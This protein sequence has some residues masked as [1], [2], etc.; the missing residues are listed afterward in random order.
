M[1]LNKEASINFRVTE[2]TKDIAINV[3]SRNEIKKQTDLH[4]MAYMLGME[5]IMEIE[6]KAA[7]ADLMTLLAYEVSKRAKK[8]IL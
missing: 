3:C 7:G 1:A 6:K 8:R 5:I 4:R 2:V